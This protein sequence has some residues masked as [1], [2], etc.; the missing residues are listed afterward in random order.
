MVG[1]TYSLKSTP[2]VNLFLLNISW[3][4]FI[5]FLSFCNKSAE[6]M[7]LKKFSSY[8]ISLEMSDL[9]FTLNK[10]THY[11]LDFGDFE[12]TFNWSDRLIFD[13]ATLTMW[14]Q[15]LNQWIRF[16]F[17]IRMSPILI[18]MYTLVRRKVGLNWPHKLA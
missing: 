1:R 10:P 9:R 7:L 17:S 16:W 18:L 2:K 14:L 4:F 15:N 12:F 3:Q 8:F 13:G 6:R 11:I 5:Y